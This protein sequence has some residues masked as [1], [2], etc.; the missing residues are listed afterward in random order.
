LIIH[1]TRI[2]LVMT[3]A[4]YRPRV[5]RMDANALAD[6]VLTSADGSAQR[7]GDRWQHQPVV[8]VFLRHFG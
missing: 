6:L 2:G 7:L 1:R 4:G 8:V 3:A 5:S